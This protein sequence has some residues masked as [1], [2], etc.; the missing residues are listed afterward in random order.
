MVC[1]CS[2]CLVLKSIFIVNTA[3]SRI[4]PQYYDNKI[5]YKFY[6]PFA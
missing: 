1:I 5:K 2:I 4:K 3:Y 6:N